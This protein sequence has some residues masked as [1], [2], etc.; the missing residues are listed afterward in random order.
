MLFFLKKNQNDASMIPS[1]SEALESILQPILGSPTTVY[2][3]VKLDVSKTENFILN[4][5]IN[6]PT[7]T[8]SDVKKQRLDDFLSSICHGNKK[9]NFLNIYKL[10]LTL[11]YG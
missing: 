10:F 9:K 6:F 8:C 4:D 2:T 1:I 5:L 7:A 3:L 11:S